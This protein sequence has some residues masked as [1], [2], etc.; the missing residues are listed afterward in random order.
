MYLSKEFGCGGLERRY[1][2]DHHFTKFQQHVYD[3]VMRGENPNVT[4]TVAAG[5]S[6]LYN[7][8][9][10]DIEAIQ[11]AVD[12]HFKDEIDPEDA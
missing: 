11:Q 3:T 8:I 1:M 4:W 2:K 10:E 5:K 12:G 9:K 7:A 6:F